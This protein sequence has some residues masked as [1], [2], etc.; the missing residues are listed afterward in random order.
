MPL[1]NYECEKC[2]K[3]S[4]ALV[5]R[6]QP[7]PSDCDAC[8]GSLK[9]LMSTFAVPQ[10]ELDK[11]RAVDPAYKR[12]VEDHMART[13]EA[14]PMRHLNKLTPFSAAEDPGDPIDF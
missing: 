12:M 1:Y 8:D 10:S 9:R 13:P 11:L 14:E 3:T 6:N 7:E 4:E 2:S 5:R